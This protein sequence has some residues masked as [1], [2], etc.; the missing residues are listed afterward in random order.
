MKKIA[1]IGICV[2]AAGVCRGQ[3]FQEWFNQKKTQVKYLL[4]QIA[5]FEVYSGYVK[6]GY[7]IASDGLGTIKKLKK[8]DWD[9]HADYF[10]SLSQVNPAVKRYGRV[11]DIIA[12][13]TYI[14]KGSSAALRIVRSSHMLSNDEMSYLEKVYQNLLTQSARDTDYLM[15]LV[16]DGSL[17]MKD[18]ERIERIDELYTSIKDKY[19]F[20]QSFSGAASVLVQQRTKEQQ[21]VN[22]ARKIHGIP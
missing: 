19:V 4:E 1:L 21:E 14:L 18:D 9:L 15:E 8:G 13:Q 6:K 7:D 10:R 5:A 20:L 12:M 22:D 2:F 16:S 17:Q 11:A 3:T